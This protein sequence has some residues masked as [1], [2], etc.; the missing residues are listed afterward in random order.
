M[1]VPRPPP[2]AATPP[3]WHRTSNEGAIMPKVAAI[4]PVTPIIP[5]VFP[6]LAVFCDDKPPNAPT[7]QSDAAR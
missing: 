5:S 1:I 6:S 2:M 4:P 7:Q 3:I